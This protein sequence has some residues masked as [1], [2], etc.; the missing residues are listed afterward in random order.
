MICSS[1]CLLQFI[2]WSSLIDQTSQRH[3][4]DKAEISHIVCH[5]HRSSSSAPVDVI[6]R[7]R[8]TGNQQPDV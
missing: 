7:V 1:E 2:V 5:R 3:I 6:C 8:Q 4:F